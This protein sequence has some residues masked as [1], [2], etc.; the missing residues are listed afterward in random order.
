MVPYWTEELLQPLESPR[1]QIKT[2]LPSKPLEVLSANEW[3]E[4][5]EAVQLGRDNHGLPKAAQT[6]PGCD[7]GLLICSKLQA[8]ERFHLPQA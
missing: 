7:E 5:T 2:G 8:S 1:I 6:K 3:A 4:P